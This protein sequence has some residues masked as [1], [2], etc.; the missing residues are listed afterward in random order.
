M[1]LT[2]CPDCANPVSTEAFVCPKCGRPT[3]KHQKVAAK[4]FKKTLI[5][6]AVLVLA[7]LGIWLLLNPK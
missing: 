3:G 5:L 6:W 2:E 1:P 7:F 4:T